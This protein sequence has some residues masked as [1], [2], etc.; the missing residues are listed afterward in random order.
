M[1]IPMP[2][3]SVP[4]VRPQ[5]S[6][7]RAAALR[8]LGRSRSVVLV[9]F[10]AALIG[11]PVSASGAAGRRPPN[12]VLGIWTEENGIH[13]TLKLEK[14]I[15]RRFGGFRNNHSISH[16]VPGNSDNAAY[17]AGRRLVY[18]NAES[19]NIKGGKICWGDF[20]DGTHDGRLAEIVRAI[21]GNRRWTHKTPYLF[22]FHHEAG[23]PSWCGTPEDYK[24]AFRHIFNYFD[25]AGILWRNGGQLK[26]VWTVTRSQMNQQRPGQPTAAEA[27]D[28]DLGPDGVTVVGDYYDL[29]G[30]DVYDK[31]Q[32]DGHLSYTD[33]HQ[34]FDPAHKYA[35]ARGKQFGI[36]EL[37]IAEGATGEK[38][39]F[40]SQVAPTLRSYGVGVAGS[41]ATLMYSNVNG[42]QPYWVDTSASSLKAFTA[43][44]NRPLFLPR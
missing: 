32:S 33:P 22:S 42:K 17:D 6:L 41:A 5:R 10:L 30:V 14:Q 31:V 12:V 20:A 19:E 24:A 2:H 4:S 15:G 27:H 38:A 13:T 9:L 23:Q 1:R 40:F 16:R 34:A 44:A 39:A 8:L 3:P 29:V 37:G 35:L 21:K 18:R 26:M 7:S 11:L 36:F 28:P 43:M 25:S